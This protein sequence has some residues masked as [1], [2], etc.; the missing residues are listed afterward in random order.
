MAPL[1]VSTEK[2]G[3]VVYRDQAHCSSTRQ[4][5]VG[6]DRIRH[7]C[8]S[9]A[10][11]GRG[12]TC[13]NSLPI[14]IKSRRSFAVNSCDRHHIT[15]QAQAGIWTSSHYFA[16]CSRADTNNCPTGNIY[17]FISRGNS[18]WDCTQKTKANKTIIST[19]RCNIFILFLQ[20]LRWIIIL[21]FFHLL[22]SCNLLWHLPLSNALLSSPATH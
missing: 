5:T 13:S 15:I 12:F 20:C 6:C 19:A 16:R 1:N 22:L 11:E 8:I 3:Y 17:H 21:L 14:Q 4:Q 2:K 9:L 7:S 18:G 10:N